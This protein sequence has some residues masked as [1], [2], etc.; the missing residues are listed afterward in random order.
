ML[1]AIIPMETLMFF[2]YLFIKPNAL[3]ERA[4]VFQ[5]VSL[6]A[7]FLLSLYCFTCNFVCNNQRLF[8]LVFSNKKGLLSINKKVPLMQDL[9]KI[10]YIAF[11][12]SAYW[13]IIN[14][15]R[16]FSTLN[17]TINS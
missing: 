5:F 10:A 17:N 12:L 2:I 3:E 7:M 1:F 6:Y 4:E 8:A 11:N 14:C 15:F 13:I 16:V 9:L